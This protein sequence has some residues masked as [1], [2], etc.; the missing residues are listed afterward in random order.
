VSAAQIQSYIRR[1]ATRGRETERI[2]PFLATYTAGSAN[3]YLNYAIPDAA[4]S[5]IADD[6]AALRAAYVR[7]GLRPRLEY[8]PGLAPAVEPALL[9]AGFQVQQR[10]P[11]MVCVPGSLV[12]LTVPPGI[13][14]LAPRTDAEIYA[15]R[16][17]QHEAYDELEPPGPDTVA[18]T[19]R[20]LSKGALAVLARDEVTGEAAGGG[21]VDVICDG[22]GELAGFAVRAKFRRRGIGAAM[23]AWLTRRAHET[24]AHTA[25][26]TPAGDAEARMYGRVGFRP[27]DEVLFLIHPDRFGG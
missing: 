11:L 7:R 6:A 4:A 18:G 20:A 8:L 13:E 15:M 22:I 27:V 21:M 23:T 10:L 3:Q 5:P 9:D 16:V 2:G 24:G 25:F 1:N 26:L 19:R 12:D 17:V 14:F